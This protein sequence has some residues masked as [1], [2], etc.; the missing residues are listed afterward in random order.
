MDVAKGI[1]DFLSSRRARIKPDDVGLPPGQ[2]RRV[3]GLRREEV[4][5]LAGV[6][7]EYYTQIERGNVA[8]VSDDVLRAVT[9]ALRLTDDETIHFFDLVRAVIGTR[10]ATRAKRGAGHKI[11]D[12]VQSLIDNM[13]NSP[14][15]IMN[16]RL[17]IVAANSL[18]R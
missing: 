2:R 16:G 1:R 11:P 3:A 15:I 4:A 8:G 5:Q 7:T 18:G 13:A 12:G 6:S 14:A 9:A 10:V 17:D